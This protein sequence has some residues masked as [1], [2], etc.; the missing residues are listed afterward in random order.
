MSVSENDCKIVVDPGHGGDDNG[1]AWGEKYDYLEED[2][3]NL[4]IAF[5]LRYDLQ[6][7]GYD[8][9]LSREKDIFVSLGKRVEM[10]N[11]WGA[12]A[13]ISLHADAFHT[14]T[15]KGISTHIYT[16]A[17][18]ASLI[19]GTWIQTELIKKFMDHTNRGVKKSNFYV[20][21]E[22]WMPAVLVECEFISNPDT[23]RF[24][25]EP[26]N[27]IALARAISKGI[28]HNF[29]KRPALA[30]HSRDISQF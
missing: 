23:R 14:I 29:N 8:V 7:A 3:L 19:L 11:S 26:E 20:I 25:K 16:K 28:Q 15:A 10:A 4:I 2:D 9:M 5:L 18:P 13:F 12:D 17:S 1:A 22:S 30:R 27:Q 24:L 6:L 21:R